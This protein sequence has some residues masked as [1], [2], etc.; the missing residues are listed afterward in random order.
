MYFTTPISYVLV[1]FLP[2][3]SLQKVK[4]YDGELSKR[5]SIGSHQEDVA[6]CSATLLSRARICIQRA[7]TLLPER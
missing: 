7:D 4:V 3:L 5:F 6:R 1:L 2:G